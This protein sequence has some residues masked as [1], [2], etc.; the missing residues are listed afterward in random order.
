MCIHTLKILYNKIADEAVSEDICNV[1]EIGLNEIVDK[2]K[3]KNVKNGVVVSQEG[4]EQRVMSSSFAKESRSLL[5]I[6]CVPSIG[7]TKGSGN[8][9]RFKSMREKHQRKDRNCHGCGKSGQN[10]DKRSCQKTKRG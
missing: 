5:P 7:S 6:I 4:K 9:K 3:R 10:H 1:A 8:S 2:M